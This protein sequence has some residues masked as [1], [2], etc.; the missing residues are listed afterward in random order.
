[1]NKIWKSSSSVALLGAFFWGIPTFAYLPR[2]AITTETLKVYAVYTTTDATCQ[3]GLVATV[4]MTATP[5]SV[6]FT[7]AIDAGA[8]S[9]SSPINC[10][11]MVVANSVT[12][13]WAAGTYT[14]Q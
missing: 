13:G 1:M 3:T 12:V 4:P 14:G 5:V 8:V 9:V 11:I 2:A 6:D 7:K 10:I